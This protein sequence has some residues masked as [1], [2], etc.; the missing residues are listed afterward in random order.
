MTKN[1]RI[2]QGK[3][4]I[5]LPQVKT[6]LRLVGTQNIEST[7][8]KNMMGAWNN[9]FIPG[10]I[11]TFLFKFYN[12]ILG[13]NSRVAKFKRTTDPSCTF[14]SLTN[15]RPTERETFAH[16]FFYCETTS[17]ILAEFFNRFFTIEMPAVE[18]YFCGNLKLHEN[19]NRAFQLTMDIFR[20][21]IWVYKLEKKIPVL[22]SYLSEVNDTLGAIYGASRKLKNETDYCDF[23]RRSGE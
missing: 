7:R 4:L 12:N 13:L 23:F 2:E 18:I 11:R 20:Y 8:L 15:C 6:F 22:S 1:S 5:K 14:C 19:E 9:N 16:L 10:K 3:N 21:H 17:R